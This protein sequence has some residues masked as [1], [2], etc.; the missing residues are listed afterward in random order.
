[1]PF[2]R[3]G[4]AVTRTAPD[5]TTERRCGGCGVFKPRTAEYFH[6][7]A[8]KPD[9]LQAHC[10]ACQRE[11]CRPKARDQWGRVVA[12]MAARFEPPPVEPFPRN[13]FVREWRRRRRDGGAKA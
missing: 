13:H 8:R 5:G 1:M 2:P 9:G 7:N 4:V 6:R 10:K 12:K 3:N 11:A